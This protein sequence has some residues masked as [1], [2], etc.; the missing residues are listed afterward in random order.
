[1]IFKRREKPSFQDRALEILYPRKGALRG[2]EYI[3]KRIRRLPDSPHRIALGFACGAFASFTPFF[4]F[5]FVVA[6]AVAYVI[7]GNLL[8]SAFGTAV[9]NPIT[10]PFIATASLH[11]GWWITGMEGE[12]AADLSFGWLTDNIGEIFWP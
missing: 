11:T 10:F 2:M 8:A 4:G 7:R 9:G 12:L 6:A 1:M 5:H 3:G